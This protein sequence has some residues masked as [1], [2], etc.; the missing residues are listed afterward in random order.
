VAAI[1]Q[2]ADAWVEVEGLCGTMCTLAGRVQAEENEQ[3]RKQ[4]AERL[5]AAYGANVALLEKKRADFHQRERESEV[6][7]EKQAREREGAE[8]A[9]LELSQHKAEKRKVRF[10]NRACAPSGPL[11]S[12]HALRATRLR[13]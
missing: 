11:R 10:P 3:K 1:K 5:A 6:R 4:A 12:L 13:R 9:K 7:R 2:S 8:R